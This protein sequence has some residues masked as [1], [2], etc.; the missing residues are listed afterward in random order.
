MLQKVTELLGVTPAQARM[1]L[2]VFLV[3]GTVGIYLSVISAAEFFDQYETGGIS[4]EEQ[5]DLL[6][7]A[8]EQMLLDR[9]KLPTSLAPG[10]VLPNEED[11]RC[12]PVLAGDVGLKAGWV[13]IANEERC[14]RVAPSS[15]R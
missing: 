7:D 5:T 2:I 11:T 3:V 9:V 1:A 12:S 6:R 14:I 10:Q 15:R 8:R 13:W 4:E